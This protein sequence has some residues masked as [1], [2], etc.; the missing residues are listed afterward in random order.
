MCD[1]GSHRVQG[2]DSRLYRTAAICH[3][4]HQVFFCE[5]AYELVAPRALRPHPRNPRRGDVDAIEESIA[6]NGFY[7]C[8]VAQRSTGYILAGNHR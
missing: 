1:W 8:V 3:S 2:L 4:F 6:E 7:G 5:Q